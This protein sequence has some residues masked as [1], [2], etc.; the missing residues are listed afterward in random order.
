MKSIHSLSTSAITFSTRSFHSNNILFKTKKSNDLYEPFPS[1]L[2]D[3]NNIKSVAKKQNL[4]N[5][6]RIFQVYITHLVKSVIEKAR[7]S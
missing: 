3:L 1:R 4:N 5:E 6:G 2:P 7:R